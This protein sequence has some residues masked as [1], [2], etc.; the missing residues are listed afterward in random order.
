MAAERRSSLEGQMRVLWAVGTVGGLDDAALLSR[1]A[2]RLGDSAK[3]AFRILV[4]RH[5]P[6]VLRTCQQVLGDRHDAEDAAQA[7]FLVLARKAP[8]LRIDSSLAPWLHGVAR[9]VAAKA[10]IRTTARR[11]AEIR[12]AIVAASVRASEGDSRPSSEDWEVVHQEVDRLPEKYRTP[13]V[14]CYLDGQTYEETARRI[15][16]PVGTVRVR[17]SRARDRL[18]DRLARRGLGP[19]RVVLSELSAA[20]PDERLPGAS[21][22]ALRPCHY[23]GVRLARGDGQIGRSDQSGPRGNDRNGINICALSLRR[24]DESHAHES[25]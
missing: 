25:W 23:A 18:R 13:V 11:Q 15:G 5:G 19:E 3:E 2:L 6:M 14:L 9:R 10:R 1:F 20:C 4:E 22:L 16:C 7:V 21:A 8:E 24:S 12:T 17:L